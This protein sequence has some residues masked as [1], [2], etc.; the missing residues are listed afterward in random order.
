MQHGRM[1][2]HVAPR[3]KDV[4]M[5]GWQG[6]LTYVGRS[7]AASPAEGAKHR[8]DAEQAR[9]LNSALRDAPPLLRKAK[10]AAR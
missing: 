3:L 5:V 8:H 1:V 6:E 7:E 9:I 2:F 10:A 4:E